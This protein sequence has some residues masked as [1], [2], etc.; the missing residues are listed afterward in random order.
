MRIIKREKLFLLTIISVAILLAVV[1]SASSVSAYKRG[2][3]AVTTNGLSYTRND[4]KFISDNGL[5]ESISDTSMDM[6]VKQGSVTINPASVGAGAGTGATGTQS[7][8]IW[9]DQKTANIWDFFSGFISVENRGVLWGLWENG[10]SY[11]SMKPKEQEL[12]GKTLKY[13][14]LILVVILSY[15]SFAYADFPKSKIL[16]GVTSIIVGLLATFFITT[17]ELVSIITSYTAMGVAMSIFFPILILLFFTM[18]VATKANPMG[19]FAQ[20]ILWVIYSAYLLIKSLVL[21]MAPMYWKINAAGTGV[22]PKEV[23]EKIPS[24]FKYIFPR[25]EAGM[26]EVLKSV[27]NYD[28]AILWVLVITA[29][30]ITAIMVFGNRYVD[31]WM[32]KMKLDAEIEAKKQTIARAEASRKIEADAMQKPGGGA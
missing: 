19:I 30:V 16:R 23:T 3:K 6:L 18:V 7:R 12:F 26:L 27:G 5:A 11:N 22:E 21:L 28:T 4:V 1:L 8:D 14:I 9:A 10:T 2:D 24:L 20:K 31:E 29:V 25:N 15:S 17:P 32:Q 13:L